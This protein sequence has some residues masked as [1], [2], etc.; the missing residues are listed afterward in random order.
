MTLIFCAEAITYHDHALLTLVQGINECTHNFHFIQLLGM[1][2]STHEVFLKVSV[3]TAVGNPLDGV[4]L[5]T[6]S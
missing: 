3:T 5:I 2:Q 4:A 6:E 1:L